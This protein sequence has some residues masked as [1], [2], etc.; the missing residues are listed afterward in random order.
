MKP[1]LIPV[2]L[3]DGVVIHI[4]AEDNGIATRSLSPT[5]QAVQQSF[6]TIQALVRGYTIHTINAFKNLGAGNVTEVNLDFGISISAQ[7]GVPYI[8][9]GT[10]DCNVKISVKCEFPPLSQ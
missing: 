6:Q 9:S 3:E 1:N 5:Q 10:A 7:T 4:Q 2:E 8:A